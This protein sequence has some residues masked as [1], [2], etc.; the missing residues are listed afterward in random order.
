LQRRLRFPPFLVLYFP[1]LAYEAVKEVYQSVERHVPRQKAECTLS[2][3]FRVVLRI[4]GISVIDG[5][6]RFA[7]ETTSDCLPKLP[8]HQGADV[9][10]ST[11]QLEHSLVPPLSQ[12]GVKP[13]HIVRLLGAFADVKKEGLRVLNG[14]ASGVKAFV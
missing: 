7:V 14:R 3:H 1:P 11:F 2:V 10:P 12:F 5:L 13:I 9:V 4:A 8:V 6:F